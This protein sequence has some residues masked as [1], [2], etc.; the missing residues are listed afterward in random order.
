MRATWH[1]AEQ[2]G[3]REDRRAHA[4]TAVTPARGGAGG[5]GRR[6][7]V[8]RARIVHARSVASKGR[9]WASHRL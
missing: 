6:Q 7:P 8:A 4:R 9:T 3:V 1:A 5:E 2:N